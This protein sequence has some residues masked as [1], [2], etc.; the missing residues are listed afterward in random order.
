MLFTFL[1]YIYGPM[2]SQFEI[3]MFAG[4][5]EATLLSMRTTAAANLASGSAGQAITG[6]TTRDLS[7]SYGSS[8][9]LTPE[10]TLQAVIYALQTI[11]PKIYGYDLIRQRRKFVV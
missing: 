10:Q 5:D 1:T 2:A 7:V 11:N 6:V 4:L 8:T 3:T 9:V